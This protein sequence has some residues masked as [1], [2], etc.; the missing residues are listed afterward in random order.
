[1]TERR[2]DLANLRQFCEAVLRAAGADVQSAA[3]ATRAMLH[4]SELGVDSH[5]VRLLPHYDIVF[6]GGRVTGAPNMKFER[7]R[8]G[9]GLLDADN[10][11]GALA[12]Y[13]A[14]DHACSLAREA[15]IGA[16]G[17][18]RTSHFGPAGAYALAMAEAGMIGIVM[19]HSDSFVRLHNGAERFHGTNPLAAAVPTGTGNP[20]LLDMATSAVP[21]NRVKLYQSL[22]IALPENTA[23][24]QFGIDTRDANNVDMLAPLGGEFGFK[25]AGLAGLIE[26]F[27]GVVT[28]MKIGP[29]ILPMGGPDT[30]T[31]RDMGAFV[32]C[33]DPDGFVGRSLLLAGMD[34]YLSALRESTARSGTK[35]MAPGDRE[36]AE[37]ARRRQEGVP[38]DPDSA[39][40]FERLAD[41]AGIPTPW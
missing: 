25:G 3:A 18:Q 33:V 38:I 9:S 23:S 36:W 24:D 22:D 13:V 19:C 34:R 31:P 4:A 37:A 41:K 2:A 26:I 32:I 5:G 28:G 10:G 39:T 6:R 15:G 21:Y 27:S 1:M 8:A 30:S 17:I 40:E 7:I 14:A 20:W 29:E 11:H 12:A 16:V 35:V